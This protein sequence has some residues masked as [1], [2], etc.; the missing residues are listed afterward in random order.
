MYSSL[1]FK[2]RL[3]PRPLAA[4]GV[5]G[6]TLMMLAA[7]LAMFDIVAP[8]TPLSGL[9]SAPIAAYEMILAG[10]LIGKGFGSPAMAGTCT[11]RHQQA[12]GRGIGGMRLSTERCWQ[13]HVIKVHDAAS[14]DMHTPALAATQPATDARKHNTMIWNKTTP[15]PD[16][17]RWFWPAWGV[18]FVGFPIGGSAAYLLLGPVETVGAAA[19]GGIVTGAA[20]APRNGWCCAGACRSRASGWR[21]PAPAW[22]SA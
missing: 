3:V 5:I 2:S 10:W 21:R 14:S 17:E 6:A 9:L 1:L 20:L 8:F 7:F 15:G 19:I 22:P 4:L 12:H 18:A 13:A 16:G 11:N